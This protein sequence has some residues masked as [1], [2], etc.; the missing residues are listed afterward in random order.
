MPP[1]STPP[2]TTTPPLLVLAIVTVIAD[3]LAWAAFHDITKGEP[4]LTTE[5][6]L[7]TVCAMWLAY[8]AVSLLRTRRWVLG[9]GSLLALAAGIWGQQGIG[10]GI[11][12]GLWPAYVATVGALLWFVALAAVLLVLGSRARKLEPAQVKR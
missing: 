3:F 1:N 11:T 8:V 9:S 7:L 6:V 5:Y 10:P 2:R 12:P 4:D